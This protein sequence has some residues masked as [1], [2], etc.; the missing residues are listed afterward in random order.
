[1]NFQIKLYEVNARKIVD[2]FIASLT[3][4]TISKIFWLFD[5][6]EKYGPNIGMPYVRKIA[7][8]LFEL[9]IRKQE[10]IRFFFTLKS[11]VII[12]LHGFKKKKMKIPKKELE[13]AKNR[14]TKYNV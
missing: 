8:N 7:I 14:L 9:R 4:R 2:D 10:S 13:I 1:M 5:L 3:D 6:L 11:N 12:I